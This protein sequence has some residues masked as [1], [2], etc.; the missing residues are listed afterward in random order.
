MINIDPIR[1]AIAPYML[2]IKLGL[3][4]V[5][6]C[7]MFIG[8]CNHGAAKWE[9]KYDDEVA[10]HNATKAAHKGV[11]DNLAALT[12][13]AAEKAKAASVVAHGERKANDQRFKDA[14]NE[15]EQAK[16]DLRAALRR[17]TGP[18]R[19][20]DEWTCPAAGSAQGGTAAAA[21][22]Q[23]AAADLRAAG[24]ADLIA[25]GDEADR[26]IVWLQSELTSTRKACSL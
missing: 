8:G 2:L 9:G 25:A 15:A 10:A 22:R 18:V 19:L 17:G 6:A 14:Q 3:V 5:L 7:S 20:R 23:D 11:I 21:R 13:A 12:K 16:R 26:W 24:A 4:V 1:A